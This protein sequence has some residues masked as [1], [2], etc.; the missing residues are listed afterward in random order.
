[1]RQFIQPLWMLS[2]VSVGVLLLPHLSWAKLPASGQSGAAQVVFNDPTPPNQGSPSGR[3]RGGGSRKGPC[4]RYLPLTALVPANSTGKTTSKHPTL[5]FYLPEKPTPETTIS[6]TLQDANDN[7]VYQ[8][9]V[10]ATDATP[11]LFSVSVPAT[12]K[13]LETGKTYSWL[14]SVSCQ[15]QNPS[16]A[17]AVYGT[18]QK[19]DLSAQL[20]TALKSASPLEQ[21]SLYAENGIWYDA[22]N[23]LAVL[24]QKNPKQQAAAVAWTS[25]MQQI[26]LTTLATQP[27]TQCCKPAEN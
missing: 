27:L 4:D 20:Q 10:A 2:F 8:T 22:L 19:S 16:T 23:T 13:P 18:L 15:P 14:L 12:V 3:R 5:W 11:G 7:Y 9:R 21:A 24:Y 17:V 26:D 25:L 1:M 6:F